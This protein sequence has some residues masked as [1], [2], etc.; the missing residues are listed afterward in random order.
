MVVIGLDL[1]PSLGSI[2]VYHYTRSSE[3]LTTVVSQFLDAKGAATFE[4]VP[5]LMHLDIDLSSMFRQHREL[6]D[7]IYPNVDGQPV[8]HNL[9]VSL[10]RVLDAALRGY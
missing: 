8:Q 10:T 6:C 2:H 4:R 3:D 5:P 1:K 7:R 9:R